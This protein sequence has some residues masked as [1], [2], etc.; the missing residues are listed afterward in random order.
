[1]TAS[2]Y[3]IHRRY[4][5]AVIMGLG[6]LFLDYFEY[7]GRTFEYHPISGSIKFNLCKRGVDSVGPDK[8]IVAVILFK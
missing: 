5:D 8:G 7:A 3:V 1:M 4:P 2:E 6:I